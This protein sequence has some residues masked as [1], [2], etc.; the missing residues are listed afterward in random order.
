MSNDG[1]DPNTKYC[2]S[3]FVD[4]KST[5]PFPTLVWRIVSYLLTNGPASPLFKVLIDSILHRTFRLVLVSIHP[6]TTRQNTAGF[7]R[8]RICACAVYQRDYVFALLFD[9]GAL[10]QA[11]H[12]Y[13]NI[14][15]SV[16]GSLG[17]S[18]YAYDKLP[19]VFANCSG[20]VSCSAMTAPS[21]PVSQADNRFCGPQMCLPHK[22][23]ETLSLV[24]TDTQFFSKDNLRQLRI[25][26]QSSASGAALATTRSCVGLSFAG[27]YNELYRSY[28]D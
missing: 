16:F 8:Y 15:A 3:K 7:D 9:V 6:R 11:Y 14:F 17:T 20:G 13:M 1:A 28:T 26:L 5:N 18:R 23:D 24:L 2:M 25:I 4:V 19:T 10:S 22:V 27:V 12:R 21:L